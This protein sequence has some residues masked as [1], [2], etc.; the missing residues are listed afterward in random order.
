MKNS[1]QNKSSNKKDLE[2]SSEAVAHLGI[3][4]FIFWLL[5][6][7]ASLR[8]GSGWI[9]NLPT[10]SWLL[11]QLL[12]WM[13]QLFA[14]GCKKPWFLQ[15]HRC[16]HGQRQ[17]ELIVSV[18]SPGLVSSSCSLSSSFHPFPSQLPALMTVRCNIECRD[19]L[20]PD[21]AL[22][23]SVILWSQTFIIILL[24][25]RACDSVL[26]VDFWQVQRI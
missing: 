26:L 14:F 5:I 19:S 4:I 15:G 9:W 6:W 17:Q 23:A 10:F 7:F 24:I 3:Y 22:L 12:G 8:Q 2:G 16:N 20:L 13:S 11:L 18:L 1:K 25:Y 21:P